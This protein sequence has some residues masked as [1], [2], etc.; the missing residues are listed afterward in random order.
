MAGMI[1]HDW[2][3]VPWER[4]RG[5][6]REELSQFRTQLQSLLGKAFTSEGTLRSTVIVNGTF[7]APDIPGDALEPTRYVA[8]TGD[9]G[10]P[11]WDQVN[12]S[13]G[14]KSRLPFA[15]LAQLAA[16]SLLG[17]AG[18]STADVAAITAASDYQVMRRSG[19]S[20]G[21][22]AID[23]SQAAAVTGVL[24]LANQESEGGGGH[25]HGLMRIAGD[26]ATT[27]FDLLDIAEYLEHVGV[28]GA[29]ADPATFSLSANGLQIVFDTA[30]GAGD[31]ILIEYV[32]AS[33]A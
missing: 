1:L 17:V 20:I 25:L 19:A 4:A 22:G 30:P 32:I 29:F 14:V 7:A 15:N 33:V 26:G 27:T 18:S 21:F 9:D 3:N 2:L 23:L 10:T 12:L 5:L 11:Q 8:N 28:A 24:P 31:V 13:N 6:V 16:R